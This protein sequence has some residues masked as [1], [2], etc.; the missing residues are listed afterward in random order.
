MNSRRIS[1]IESSDFRF[2]LIFLLLRKSFSQVSP[3]NSV[4]YHIAL[5]AANSFIKAVLTDTFF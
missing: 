5:R 3:Y 2:M 1:A 4:T